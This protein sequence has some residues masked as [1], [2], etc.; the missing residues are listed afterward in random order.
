[1]TTDT[2]RKSATIQ[3]IGDLIRTQD[4]R[5]TADPLFVVKQKK[6]IYGI[7]SNYSDDYEWLREDDHEHVADRIERAGL[8]ALEEDG[9]DVDGWEKLYYLDTWEF[10]T[11]CF[12]EQA[13]KDYITANSHNLNEPIIYAASAYRNWEMIAIREFLQ[14]RPWVEQVSKLKGLIRNVID[15][16]WCVTDLQEAIGDL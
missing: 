3:R 10:V 7:D 2:S 5:C 6:R 4:N 11:V 1:M 8:D 9:E 15:G 14:E 16:K 12:T 13:C